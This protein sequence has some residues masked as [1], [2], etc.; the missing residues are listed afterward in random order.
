MA[1]E[2]WSGAMPYE[3]YQR[4]DVWKGQQRVPFRRRNWSQRTTEAFR[5]ERVY[6][7]LIDS[8]PVSECSMAEGQERGEFVVDSE[9][10]TAGWQ[11]LDIDGLADGESCPVWFA[12]VP[13]AS[14]AFMP[15]CTG[16][17]DVA[18]SP[19]ANHEH[20]WAWKPARYTPGGHPLPPRSYDPAPEVTADVRVDML[21][22]GE[23]GNIRHANVSADG[24]V[25]SFNR[26][27]YFFDDLTRKFPRVALMDGPRGVGTV[28]M[29]TH[30]EVGRATQTADTNSAPMLN[31]YVCD[32]WRLMRVTDSGHVTTLVGYRHHGMPSHWADEP[33]ATLELVGDWRAIPEDRRGF[34]ELWGMAWDSATLAV[35]GE[36]I[37]GREPHL[38]G[39]ACVV[40]DSQNNRVCL[41]EFDPRSHETPAKV[42]EFATGLMDPWD[43]VEWR[44][45]F[46]VSE[47]NANRI[48]ALD[49]R[50]SFRR[51]V[52]GADPTLPGSASLQVGNPRRMV[53]TGS[54]AEIQQQRCLGP[55]GLFVQDDWL[56]FG[57]FVQRQL[58]RLHLVDGRL[59]VVSDLTLDGNSVFVK[60]A[61]S[62]GAFGPRG[63]AWVQTW[64]LNYSAHQGGALPDG[65]RWPLSRQVPWGSSG[66]G[67]AV[68]VGGGRLY[69]G[70]SDYGLRRY[71]AGPT[72]NRD[73][74]LSEASAYK[75]QRLDVTHGP[76]GFGAGDLAGDYMREVNGILHAETL[77]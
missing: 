77:P 21:V 70:S 67:S 42:T 74:Y 14:P 18:S 23:G 8:K 20:V 33:G 73:R 1:F 3:R 58:R 46:I 45:E 22:P 29:P 37:D 56:Y 48:I 61:L 6:T 10:L 7:L 57:S 30:I 64:S 55:E 71:S 50:G 51:V 40:T 47:R 68:G 5:P 62:D 53:G 41:I 34:H 12:F 35:G 17:Y 49:K 54:L 13:G 15:V 31:I 43:V 75:A 19:G 4:L 36:P 24:I 2:S 25:S 28:C 26:Q 39:P 27:A 60:F 9:A 69:L 63:T 72:W 11:T 59:E 16:S 44:D 65:T 52:I 32:P 76:Q 66:Y 38:V